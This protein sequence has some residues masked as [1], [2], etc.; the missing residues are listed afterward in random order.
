MERQRVEDLLGDAAAFR[1]ARDIRAYV[2]EAR[3]ANAGVPGLLPSEDMEAWARWALAQADRIEPVMTGG[4]H[5][6]DDKERGE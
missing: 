3:T 4:F 2:D 6:Q 5:R 1:R